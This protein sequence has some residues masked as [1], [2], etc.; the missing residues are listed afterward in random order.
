MDTTHNHTRIHTCKWN[1]T[2]I[3]CSTNVYCIYF[4]SK[5]LLCYLLNN[6]FCIQ[7]HTYTQIYSGKVITTTLYIPSWYECDAKPCHAMPCV[8]NHTCQ[9]CDG[10]HVIHRF[11]FSALI[12]SMNIRLYG[13]KECRTRSR[14]RNRDESEQ[15]EEKY[16]RILDRVNQI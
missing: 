16:F 13:Y 6:L 11:Q 12:S 2:I 1:Q 14:T 15:Q 9:T 10:M 5:I 8:C 3:A 4:L 7:P